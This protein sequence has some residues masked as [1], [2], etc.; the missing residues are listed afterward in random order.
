MV[1]DPGPAISGQAIGITEVSAKLL[2]LKNVE[3]RIISNATKNRTGFANTRIIQNGEKMRI[4]VMTL[5]TRQEA[6]K[7]LATLR[8]NPAHS[9]AWLLIQ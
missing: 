2:C 6:E 9:D 7:E 5:G 1:I 4:S 8:S 3:S